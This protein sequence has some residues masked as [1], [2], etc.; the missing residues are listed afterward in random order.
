MELSQTLFNVGIVAGFLFF[1]PFG[2]K[3]G[4]KKMFFIC[5][6]FMTVF[7]IAMA[8]APIFELFCTFQFLTGACAA[9]SSFV[10]YI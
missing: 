3:Y 2:D 4:R 7:G 5:Q 6:F 8:F 9:V 10:L 1:T